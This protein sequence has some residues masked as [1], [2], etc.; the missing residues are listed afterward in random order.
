MRFPGWLSACL[1][2]SLACAPLAQSA[3]P[4]RSSLPISDWRRSGVCYEIFVRSFYD[5]N[6]DGIGDL[7]GLTAKLDYINDGKPGGKDL[8]ARCVW[9]MPIVASPSYHGYDATDYYH[10]NKDYGTDADFK[11][12]VRAAHA[13]GIHVLVDMVLNHTSNEH[14][15][16]QAA[17]HDTASPYRKY[18]RFSPTEPAQKGPWGQVAW[19]KSPVRNEWYYG[20][21]W[22]GMPD[23]NYDTPAVRQEA[24][25]IARY[26][27]V[28][29][30]VDG[31][32]LDAVPYLVE[33]GDTLAGSRGTHRLL[34]EYARYVHSVRPSA[35]TVGEVYDSIGTML[36]YYPD[37]L[38]DYFAFGA[39]DA[40]LDGVRTGNA[41]N[42]L[43]PFLRLQAALPADR[44]APFQR[45]HDQPR[46]MTVLGG[47]RQK[48]REAVTLL[49]TLP[50]FPFVYYGEEIGMSGDKPD[51][52]LRTPMQW[53]SGAT[54]GF[55][56][57][58]P[59]EAPQSDAAATNVAAQTD[60]ASSLL[61]L[62]RKL[63]ALRGSNAALAA[64]TLVPLTTSDPSV[65]AYARRAGRRTVIVVANLGTTPKR[66]I[67]VSSGNDALARGRYA[68]RSLLDATRGKMVEVTSA[69]RFDGYQPID[70]LAAESAY[71]IELS[72][73]SK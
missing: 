21:F 29:M 9:L 65:V 72:L 30:G 14:P 48:A 39:S 5:S 68:A 49:L 10:V 6:G 17:L 59:W 16:F 54:V 11:R 50:G 25:K 53:T 44:Y 20:V 43:A 13:R 33:E 71:V 26:W 42:V 4:P 3:H 31:F 56:T 34:A 51:E 46:T 35:F 70:T 18:Y 41:A 63:I 57:A 52:R 60:D 2:L 15:W 7:N 66:G 40:L 24:K 12:F 62:Y 67:T 8:G 61:S 1:T 69:G 22:S 27:L 55:T 32:R 19:H 38:D 36:T 64:G 73:T 47:D 23:L 28:D 58:K 45:N 37:Q